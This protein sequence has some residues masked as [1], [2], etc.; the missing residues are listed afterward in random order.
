MYWLDINLKK[1]EGVLV[2]KKINKLEQEYNEV[3]VLEL[4]DSVFIR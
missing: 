3:T 4:K 2:K 1:N